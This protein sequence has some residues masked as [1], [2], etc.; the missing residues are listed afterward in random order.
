[1]IYL[2]GDT[3][4]DFDRVAS[5]CDKVKST[6]EDI[7]V[8]LGDAGINY[9]GNPKDER[10]KEFLH[11]LPIT[12]LCIHGNHEK[13]PQTISSYQKTLWQ[14]GT[15]YQEPHHPSLLFAMDGEIYDLGGKRCIAIGGAYSV[16]KHYRISRQ[17]GWWAD[18]QPS[19]QIK[20]HVEQRLESVGWDIDIVLTHT[21]PMK[22]LPREEFLPFIDQSTVDN[23]T[24]IWLDTLEDKLHY[25]HWYCGHYHTDKNIDK[26]SFLFSS[27]KEL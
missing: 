25:A 27:Y 1:M 17:W 3:H 20:A 5:F 15:V 12:L 16:D 24:E 22:Y 7:L 2:T 13:R 23:S 4:G 6:K 14:G 21:C 10:L 8:V 18:E 26:I 9:Y 19:D 11:D